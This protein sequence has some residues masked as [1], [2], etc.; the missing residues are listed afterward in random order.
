MIIDL[1]NQSQRQIMARPLILGAIASPS[2]GA[3]GPP[4]GFVGY[5]PQKRV[6]YDT[7]EI[8]TMYI[9]ESGASLYDNLNHIRYRLQTLESGSGIVVVDFLG[10]TDT[11]DSYAG[12]EGKYVVVNAS[13]TGLVFSDGVTP[14][15]SL[16]DLTDVTI[17]TPSGGEILIYNELTSE[18][19]NTPLTGA[20]ALTITTEDLTS[21][22]VA[23]GETHFDL[24][25][26]ADGVMV[27]VNGTLQKPAD[28]TLDLDGLGFTLA[29]GVELGDNLI[30]GRTTPAGTPAPSTGGH[31]IKDNNVAM[32]TRTGLNFV[33]FTVTDD[34]I[35]DNTVVEVVIPSG[36]SP[37]HA[38]DGVDGTNKLAQAN[39]HE[40]PDTD[41]ATSSLHH[42]LGSGANQAA[43]GNHTHDLVKIFHSQA[44]LSIEGVVAVAGTKP[45]R[46]YIPYVGTGATIEEVFVSVATA[47]VGAGLQI[48]VNKNGS[49]IFNVTQYVEIGVGAYTATKSTDF[50]TTSLAKD[51]YLT[52]EVVLQNATASDLTVHVR[53][54]WELTGV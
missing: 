49:S 33:G 48:D 29:W 44:I 42:T 18:W 32:T 14:V 16:N 51:D 27:W 15:S 4:G 23:G 13:G 34:A 2:G 7:D 11:P 26:A 54:K 6:G 28:V 24:S 38:H 1:I 52:I 37:S 9:P 46:V 40:S 22:I 25:T 50:A 41:V 36:L 12:S 31:T 35:N 19:I 10:L 21:Q 47:P 43:A 30:A 17:T 20:F 39:T 3:G 53:Y 8:A 5:L 45:L